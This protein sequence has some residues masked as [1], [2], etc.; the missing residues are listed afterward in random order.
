VAFVFLVN[1]LVLSP[2][3]KPAF[4]TLNPHDETK[5]IDSGR[6]LLELQVRGAN[7]G[8]LV[9]VVYAP[10]H[11]IFQRSLDWFVWEAF[12]GRVVLFALLWGA[13]FYLSTKFRR[14]AHP[15]VTAGVLFVTVSFL[16]TLQNQSDALYL[17]CAIVALAKVLD[18]RQRLNLRDLVLASTLV[19]LGVLARVESILLLGILPIA[20]VVIA[21]R[22]KPILK[23]LG[24]ALLP[25]LAILAAYL[26]VTLALGGSLDSGISRKSWN[27]FEMNQPVA[28]GQ[29]PYE[30]TARLY[31]TGEE[32]GY[33]V[34]RA[35]LRNP[36][37]FAQRIAAN[38]RTL[39]ASYLEFFGKRL[40]FVVLLM[41]AWGAYALLRRRDPWPLVLMVVWAAPAAVSLAFLPRHFVPQSSYLPLILAAI[42]VAFPLSEEARPA[43]ETAF[44][45]AAGALAVFGLATNKLAVMVGGVY[46]LA[47]VVLV[48][49]LR[50]SR[51]LT[52]EAAGAPLLL[53]FAAGLLLRGPFSF[54][55]YPH[56]GSS[57]PEK[58]VHFME[59]NLPAGSQVISTVPMPAVAA[60]MLEVDP[61]RL[62][63]PTSAEAVCRGLRQLDVRA[64]F[65]EASLRNGDPELVASLN[66][67]RGAGVEVGITADPGSFQ[68][69]VVTEPCL[70]P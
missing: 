15:F 24:A 55:D 63:D 29:D 20:A 13:L 52:R 56:I 10:L 42:G 30:V 39:P 31:G 65:V 57:P 16:P 41:A 53:A 58:A 25:G 5:Y 49:L 54:P 48:W 60:G 67:L 70:G 61:S 12:A 68:V 9:A 43:E 22:R 46:V 45:V 4:D 26:V 35:V 8:P 3:L 19:A 69:F 27:S 1:L 59:L 64:I 6:S 17:A 7:W 34:V 21:R 23:V 33:S 11:L 28:S 32:N 2:T 51:W 62:A 66:E 40:G 36:A 14:H 44:A 37:A 18:F 50:R 47:V 38:G